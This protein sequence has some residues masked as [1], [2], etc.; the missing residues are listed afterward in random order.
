MDDKT[1]IEY[2]L[3]ENGE[4][5]SSPNIFIIKKKQ[6]EI[7]LGDIENNLPIK[8]N[9]HLRFKYSLKDKTYWLDF[10]NREKSV[11]TFQNKTIFENG[12]II[13]KINNLDIEDVEDEY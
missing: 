13:I 7:T 3:P 11:P 10:N 5:E 6:D 9:F 12:K 1:I 2:F 4:K 8:G